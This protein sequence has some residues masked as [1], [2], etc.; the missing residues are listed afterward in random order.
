MLTN[1]LC[2]FLAKDFIKSLLNP[3]P[4]KRPTAAEALNHTWLTTHTP[5]TEHDLS[6]GLRD[7]FD[8]RA[9]WR[10]AIAG[11]RAMH[12][13]GSFAK[14]AAAAAKDN[15]SAG[16]EASLGQN[17][18]SLGVSRSSS[19]HST[20]SG[21]SGGWGGELSR[22]T[23]KNEDDEDDD[24]DWHPGSGSAGGSKTA[25]NN[26]QDKVSKL[27][28]GVHPGENDNVTITSPDE[29]ERQRQRQQKETPATSSNPKSDSQSKSILSSS[30]PLA[31]EPESVVND[32]DDETDKKIKSMPG[33][34]DMEESGSGS[35]GG[36]TGGTWG[37]MLKKLNLGGGKK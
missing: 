5:S 11:A 12:R 16:A 18:E 6:S 31:E 10:S 15:D 26:D 1:S 34:F 32:E 4:V 22:K 3:D 33:S 20:T 13:L 2:S 8:P 24:G 9:R 35:G 30:T 28:G 17:Q 25:G 21:S 23:T 37:D 19:I 14:A 36:D 27:G 7:N 29:V